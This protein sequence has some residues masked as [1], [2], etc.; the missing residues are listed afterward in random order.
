MLCVAVVNALEASM[1]AVSARMK[2]F[3]GIFCGPC[4]IWLMS[5]FVKLQLTRPCRT[6]FC[7]VIAVHRIRLRDH[8]PLVWRPLPEYFLGLARSVVHV[9]VAVA[10]LV[11]LCTEDGHSGN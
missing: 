5:S 1:I 8:R 10:V 7:L 3:P 4:L 9:G 6:R 2:F 11:D